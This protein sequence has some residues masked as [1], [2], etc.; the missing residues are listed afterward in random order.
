MSGPPRPPNIFAGP[1]LDRTAH[2]REDTEW[3]DALRGQRGALLVPVWQ[4]RNL[5]N[6]SGGTPTARLLEWPQAAPHVS[7]SEDLILL[8]EFR[9]R[10]CFAFEITSDA[11][12][13]LAVDAEFHDLRGIGGEL[14]GDEAGL[15][16]YARAMVYWRARHRFCGACGAPTASGR[17]GHLLK[18][19]Q[20]GTPQFPRI[21]P[22]IIVLVSGGEGTEERALLGR[23]AIWPPGRYS[24][25]AG[26]VEPGESLEDAVI[27]EVLEETGI[28][29]TAPAY[30]SS[31]PWPFPASLMLGFTARA[32]STAIACR[33]GEL[34]DARW[35]SRED[36]AMGKILLPPPQSISCR[37]IQDWLHGSPGSGDG[38]KHGKP[39]IPRP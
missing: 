32:R 20:C 15:L 16:A 33:D 3:L 12:P 9:N 36:V 24:T 18:C 21:D 13:S 2:P 17:S 37:L 14:P 7:R 10:L 23:Q 27:R 29:A 11:P 4:L 26:F 5:I 35:F 30:H 31:Q 25:I 28:E 22:A 38:Q 1:Y 39:A 8:G 34:E 6:P 19:T